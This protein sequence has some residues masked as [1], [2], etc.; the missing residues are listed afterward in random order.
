MS[1]SSVPGANSVF[2]ASLPIDSLPIEKVW[3]KVCGF[4]AP[5]K[6]RKEEVSGFHETVL[7][8][9][10]GD[11]TFEIIFI[12]V[13]LIANGLFSMSEMAVVSA[14]KARRQKRAIDGD[15]GAQ[16][17]LELAGNPGPF[18]STVQIGIT[19]VGILAGAFGGAT[20]AE[21]L[22]PPL[23]SFPAIET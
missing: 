23:K 6:R 4:A 17:A 5:V 15:K 11:I 21:K 22:A 9:T 20:I 1:I 3:E 10:M 14:R 13:L 19:L 2:L 7:D 8:Q 16:A 12:I 18:L